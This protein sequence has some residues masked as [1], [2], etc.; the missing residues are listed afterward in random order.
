MRRAVLYTHTVITTL[1]LAVTS[2]CSAKTIFVDPTAAGDKDGSSWTDAYRH[3]QNALAAASAGDQIWVA[4]GTYKPDRGAGHTLGDRNAT[5]QL[6]NGVA[7]FG[8]F[9]PGGGT[10]QNRNTSNYKTILTGDLTGNDAKDP[11]SENSPK[12]RAENSF[13]VVTTTETDQTAFLDGFTITAGNANARKQPND[14]G[15]GI[16][17]SDGAPTIANCIF[18]ANHAAGVY[19]GGA[20]HNAAKSSPTLVNCAFSNNHAGYGAAIYNKDGSISLTNCTFEDHQAYKGGAIRN[21]SSDA[22]LTGCTF[23]KNSAGDPGGAICSSDGGN[24]ELINCKFTANS[25][26]AGG[27]IWGGSSLTLTNCTFTGNSASHKGGAI[28]AGLNLRLSECVFTANS[29]ELGGT[30]AAY[31]NLIITNCLFVRNS[32]KQG[33]AIHDYAEART[34]LTNSTF[35]GNWAAGEGNAIWCN[36]EMKAT[37]CIIFSNMDDDKVRELGHICSDKH[38]GINYCC[39]QY[40]QYDGC[41]GWGGTGNIK[42]DP[43]FAD[44]AGGDYH[45]LPDSPCIDAGRKTGI[46]NDLDG[47]PRPQG[48][49]YDMGSYE[50]SPSTANRGSVP[51][52]APGRTIFRHWGNRHPDMNAPPLETAIDRADN[53][54]AFKKPFLDSNG[55]LVEL[56]DAVRKKI[57]EVNLEIF[58]STTYE[59]PAK[60]SDMFGPVFRLELPDRDHL[61]LYVSKIHDL[62]MQMYHM[63]MLIIHDTRRNKVTPLPPRF[64][65]RHLG[66]T[67]IE[68]PL[69]S[70]DDLNGDGKCE[71]VF[72]H[73]DYHGPATA[74]AVYRYFHI[75]PDLILNEIFL[76]KT[77]NS[78]TGRTQGRIIR[79]IEKVEPNLIV[80]VTSL[81]PP[82]PDAENIEIGYAVFQS[83]NARSPFKLRE[84]VVHVEKY[85]FL[86]LWKLPGR[87][88]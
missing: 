43:M 61:H 52:V 5:F 12:L 77:R 56:P 38:P 70:F 3:L 23:F 59:G 47:N 4:E 72:Q 29:A 16:Y 85:E 14:R 20:M 41:P 15:G 9:P 44:P 75:R 30:I 27:A 83:P 6:K 60:Y 76:L 17:N 33:G 66:M 49:D 36:G 65:A 10:W 54:F 45:L 50:W 8:G 32:A 57:C 35:S 11:E 7:I 46:A 2:L 88:P 25:A 26:M 21:K 34:I 74:T 81:T 62:N 22:T 39:I 19:G 40:Y 48:A 64:S 71:L 63:F 84:K 13:H 51:V 55:R 28:S 80:V 67:V 31:Q 24:L 68:P 79:S 53:D 87:W 58:Q 78:Y 73:T 18:T 42:D 69:I 86:V 1:L 82:S 37:N